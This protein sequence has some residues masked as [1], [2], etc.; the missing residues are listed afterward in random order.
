MPRTELRVPVFQYSIIITI[1]TSATII[2]VFVIIIIII[3]LS[4]SFYISVIHLVLNLILHI[5]GIPWTL[6]FSY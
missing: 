2:I 3:L 5:P 4:P 1:T 6:F